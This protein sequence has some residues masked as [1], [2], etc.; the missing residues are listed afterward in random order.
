MNEI[1]I[2]GRAAC[3]REVRMT[4][5]FTSPLQGKVNR[6]GLIPKICTKIAIN[7]ERKAKQKEGRA[8]G[9]FRLSKALSGATLG[10]PRLK[11]R[12]RS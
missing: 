2:E 3:R 5:L 7:G 8:E 12:K 10:Q 11:G 6:E 1:I 4:H 9:K